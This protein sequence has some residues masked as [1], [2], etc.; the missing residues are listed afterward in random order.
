MVKYNKKIDNPSQNLSIDASCWSLVM[1]EDHRLRDRI[2][3]SPMVVPKLRAAFRDALGTSY[4]LP[5]DVAD[6]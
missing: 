5:Y 2:G 1:T 4:D 3:M 6:Q